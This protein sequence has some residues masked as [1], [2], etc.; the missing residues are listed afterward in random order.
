MPISKLFVTLRRALST[1]VLFTGKHAFLSNN[2]S[3]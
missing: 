1:K 3:K 2:Q